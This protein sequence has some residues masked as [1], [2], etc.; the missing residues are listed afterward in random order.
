[1]RKI[2]LFL[3][4]ISATLFAIEQN[5]MDCSE[6][7]DWLM[8]PSDKKHLCKNTNADTVK[9]VKKKPQQVSVHKE[10]QTGIVHS[11]DPNGDGFLSIRTKPKGKEIGKLYNGDKV[12]ILDKRGKW[13]KV[14]TESSGQVGWAHGNWIR[15]NQNIKA[16]VTNLFSSDNIKIK[17]LL[18]SNPSSCRHTIEFKDGIDYGDKVIVKVDDYKIFELFNNSSNIIHSIMYQSK[19]VISK[20]INVTLLKKNRA[21]ISN[22]NQF[23]IVD[24]YFEEGTLPKLCTNGKPTNK[25]KVKQKANTIKFIVINEMCKTNYID[26]VKIQSSQGEI[27][28]NTTPLMSANMLFKIKAENNF[29]KINITA[30]ASDK[31]FYLLAEK[32]KVKL[33]NH[34]KKCNLGNVQ[35]C[36][37]AGYIYDNVENFSKA[38]Y[39]FEKSCNLNHGSGCF[40]LGYFYLKGLG[41]TTK[42][43]SKA[44]HIYKKSCDLGMGLG[45]GTYKSLEANQKDIKSDYTLKGIYG[46][47]FHIDNTRR[48]YKFHEFENKVVILNM[49]DMEDPLCLAHLKEVRKVQREHP[50]AVRVL[51]IDVRNH[52]PRYVM[53]TIGKRDPN[54]SFVINDDSKDVASFIERVAHNAH[55]KGTIPFLLVFNSDHEIYNMFLGPLHQSVFGTLESVTKELVTKKTIRKRDSGIF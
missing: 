7:P 17:S 47:E 23:Q 18:C 50:D 26:M 19:G 53:D 42:D 48:G 4:L 39:F 31:V 34:I 38:K 51:N 43:R 32:R 36:Y 6:I 10:I 29:D 33:S 40:R 16:E 25:V 15:V 45:C 22:S 24:P 35:N 52:T 41:G 9:I 37:E 27:I 46:D 2:L 20:V 21:T 13:Y 54:I 44:K 28:I 30:Y 8:S 14:K 1:M 49:T 12:K 11:L 3:F 5:S 55:W